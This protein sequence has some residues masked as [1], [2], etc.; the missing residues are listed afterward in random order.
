MVTDYVVVFMN[1]LKLSI[2]VPHVCV[3]S[4]KIV[5]KQLTKN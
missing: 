4:Q 1:V 5:M 2:K 3:V